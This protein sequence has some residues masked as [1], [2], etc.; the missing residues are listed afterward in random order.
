MVRVELTAVV[1]GSETGL[2]EK[3]QAV[4]WGNPAE[5]ANDTLLP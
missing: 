5:Q 3:L 2:V 1:L 4:P